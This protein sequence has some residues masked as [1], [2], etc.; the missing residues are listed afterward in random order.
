MRRLSTSPADNSSR[1][2]T[3]MFLMFARSSQIL[4][5]WI[6]ATKLKSATSVLTPTRPV[7][8]SDQLLQRGV[9]LSG[10]QKARVA[11]GIYIAT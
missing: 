11:L 6:M 10:G 2:G 3:T 1:S 8:I 9:V 4:P 5:S 7:H